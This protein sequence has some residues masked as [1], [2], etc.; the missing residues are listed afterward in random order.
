MQE[1]WKLLT[2]LPKN[3]NL[4]NQ[5]KK[6][7]F[8]NA[9]YFKGWME[10]LC[11]ASET[12]CAKISYVFDIL[13]G[14]LTEEQKNKENYAK[15]LQKLKEKQTLCFIYKLFKQN[16]SANY[17]PLEIKC[18]SYSLKVMNLVWDTDIMKICLPSEDSQKAI[19][20]NILQIL[21]WT[22]SSGI[23]LISY[24]DT[25]MVLDACV[26][27]EEKLVQINQTLFSCESLSEN[28]L[29]ILQPGIST[30]Q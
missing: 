11:I 3:E 22:L 20:A 23:S 19:W 10:Y 29:L 21:N 6:L 27:L 16:I 7:E 13:I 4:V 1:T 26:K 28:Y 2:T 14:I 25:L 18:V 5:L 24:Q 30:L 9:D 12:D 17:S 15:Y 8:E